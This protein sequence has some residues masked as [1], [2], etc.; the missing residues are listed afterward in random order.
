MPTP[1]T[2]NGQISANQ[3]SLMGTDINSD[4]LQN[5]LGIESDQINEMLDSAPDSAAKMLGVGEN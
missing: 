2:R 1:C 3:D 4:L 5:L